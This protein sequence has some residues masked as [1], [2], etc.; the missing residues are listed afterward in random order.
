MSVRMGL[1]FSYPL[2]FSLEKLKILDYQQLD[3]GT[4]L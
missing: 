1:R 3:K 4:H 2:F